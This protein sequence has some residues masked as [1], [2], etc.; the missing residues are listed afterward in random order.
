[1]TEREILELLLHKVT[2]IEDDQQTM[3]SDIQN[4]KD[5]QQTMKSDIQTLKVD[6]QTM[7]EEQ[8]QIK[9]A[10]METNESVKKLVTIQESQHQILKLLSFRSIE[11]EASLTDLK[12]VK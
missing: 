3:K 12:S 2:N 9:Q 10:V 7:K 6:Q 1:M 5:D 8:Q 4:I 11:Q